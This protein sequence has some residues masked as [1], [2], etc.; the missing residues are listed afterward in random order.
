[1]STVLISKRAITGPSE[2]GGQAEV[3]VVNSGVAT[4]RAVTLGATRLDQ[5]EVR[6]GLA[7]GEAVI[8]NPPA[9]LASGGR[10]K[11]RGQ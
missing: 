5:V 10:V 11:V 2:S 9:A 8:L 3:W 7:P 4:R 6:S 1:V